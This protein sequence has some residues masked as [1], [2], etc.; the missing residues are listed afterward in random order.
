MQL[1]GQLNYNSKMLFSKLVTIM[2]F[3]IENKTL[4]YAKQSRLLLALKANQALL[5]FA[6]DN[7]FTSLFYLQNFV[8]P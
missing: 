5:A 3:T 7:I 1:F 6:Q 2:P 4:G 8:V